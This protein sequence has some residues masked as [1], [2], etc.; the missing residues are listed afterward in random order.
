M[1][2]YIW[3]RN[4]SLTSSTDGSDHSYRRWLRESSARLSKLDGGLGV[5]DFL[6]QTEAIQAMWIVRYIGPTNSNWKPLLDYSLLD[7]KDSHSREIVLSHRD[8]APPQRKE[9]SAIGRCLWTTE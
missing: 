4:P 3:K 8:R 9:A 5:P 1:N 7:P 6:N 2:H